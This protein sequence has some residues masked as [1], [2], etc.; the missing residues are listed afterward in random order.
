[1]QLCFVLGWNVQ[2]W[3]EEWVEFQSAILSLP[4]LERTRYEKGRLLKKNNGVL[5][6]SLATALATVLGDK[7]S[8]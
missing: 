3:T 6:N 5:E 8:I 7:R 1:M 2:D 4:L